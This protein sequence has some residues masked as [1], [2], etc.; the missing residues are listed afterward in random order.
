M[1]LRP[2]KNIDTE[3]VA[4]A[5]VD[6]FSRLG[7]HEEILSDL[8]TQFVSECMKEVTR[9]LG[10]K[11]L[12][13]TRYHKTGKGLTETFNG[14]MKSML[15]S[16]DSGTATSTRYCLHIVKFLRSLLVFR[17][18]SCFMEVLSEDRCLF[19]KSS[20]RKS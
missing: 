15:K 8:G 20:G 10:I 14:I 12:I 3:T 2:L 6:T 16:Q 17:R 4:E 9:L 18:L 1:I 13:T 19:L 7:V 5:L 11:Q